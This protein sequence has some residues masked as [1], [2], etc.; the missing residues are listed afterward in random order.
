MPLLPLLLLLL[1]LLLLPP[2]YEEWEEEVGL[3][4][5]YPPS[6]QPRQTTLLLLLLRLLLLVLSLFKGGDFAVDGCVVVVVVEGVDAVG[7]VVDVVVDVVVGVVVDAMK[8][9]H[10]PSSAS[11]R[12]TPPLSCPTAS[13]FP[14][15][16]QQ[17]QVG[18]DSNPV[19]QRRDQFIL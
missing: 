4:S 6:D 13:T 3:F 12:D 11:S 8:W 15:G 2:E 16:L 10:P 18:G 9:M 14:S 19:D 5:M 1:L 17:R 7:V